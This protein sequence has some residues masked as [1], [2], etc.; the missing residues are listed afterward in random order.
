MLAQTWSEGQREWI[1]NVLNSLIA[2]VGA[3]SVWIYIM[4]AAVLLLLVLICAGLFVLI[5]QRAGGS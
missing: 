2:Y 4:L 5:A 3:V 1:L